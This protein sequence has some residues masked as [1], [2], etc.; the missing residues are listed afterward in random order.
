MDGLPSYLLAAA[1]A[2]SDD[3]DGD[4]HV[5]VVEQLS[6]MSQIDLQWGLA[7]PIIR[8]NKTRVL[9]V[10][11]VTTAGVMYSRNAK[12]DLQCRCIL[13]RFFLWLCLQQAMQNAWYRQQPSRFAPACEISRSTMARFSSFP[14]S[15]QR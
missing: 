2:A 10:L 13:H 5:L 12:D 14:I 6:C 4:G 7:L 11:R 8:A 9:V 1:A 15:L 3:G